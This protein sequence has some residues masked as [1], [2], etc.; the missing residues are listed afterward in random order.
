M[1]QMFF[2][3][4][5]AARHLTKGRRGNVSPYVEIETI[6]SHIDSMNK[7]QT[8]KTISKYYTKGERCTFSSVYNGLAQNRF[9]FSFLF[10]SK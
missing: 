7:K 10:Y 3:Q 6:T 8:T 4:I 5:I 1:M 2:G 9:F